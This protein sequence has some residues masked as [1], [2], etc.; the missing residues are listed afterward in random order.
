MEKANYTNKQSRITVKFIDSDDSDN[1]IELFE[2]KDRNWSNVG[3]LFTKGVINNIMDNELKNKGISELPKNLMILA[4][5]EYI[6][7]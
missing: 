2:I 4:V 6:N 1:G 5:S 7:E 3:E